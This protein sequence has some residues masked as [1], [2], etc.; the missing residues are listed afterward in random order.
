MAPM[1]VTGI[2]TTSAL[3]LRSLNEQLEKRIDAEVE[4]YAR[5]IALLDSFTITHTGS[6][7]TDTGE[8]TSSYKTE[9][10]GYFF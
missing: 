2:D 1:G 4:G 5:R 7:N 6:K 10:R 3:M 9:H 8:E